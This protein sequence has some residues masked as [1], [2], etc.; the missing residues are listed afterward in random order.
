MGTGA[1]LALGTGGVVIDPTGTVTFTTA[2]HTYN[3]GE[4]SVNENAGFVYDGSI[5]SGQ[6]VQFSGAGSIN[7]GTGLSKSGNT[8][9]ILDTAVTNTNATILVQAD[10]IEVKYEAAG[11]GTGGLTDVASG[12]RVLVE[13]AGAAAGGLELVTGGL[14][15]LAS[16]TAGIELTASGVAV[17]LEAAGVGE[18]GLAFDSG[19]IRLSIDGTG[20]SKPR[21]GHEAH[22]QWPRHRCR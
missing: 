8:L 22:G 21:L 18:G 10:S 16:T 1:G 7:A 13:G 3:A 9:N 12:L 20:G 19:E 14:A 11:A 6:W 17:N 4:D 2:T 15:V 5:P